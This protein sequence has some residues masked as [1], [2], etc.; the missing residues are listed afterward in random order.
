VKRIILLMAA[1]LVAGT[2]LG[3]GGDTKAG[4]NKDRDK[5]TAGKKE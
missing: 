5:P 1:I 2:S 4:I 3:C